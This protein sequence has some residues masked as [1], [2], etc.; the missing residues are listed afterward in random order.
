MS[1]LGSFCCNICG[2]ADFKSER[3]L[4]MH[5][6]NS[7]KCKQDA[8][9]FPWKNAPARHG[10]LPNS[11]GA[12]PP[13][14][15]TRL[16]VQNAKV[17]NPEPREQAKHEIP[18][19]M[20]AGGS[21]DDDPQPPFPLLF[22]NEYCGPCEENVAIAEDE[23]LKQFREYCA[24]QRENTMPFQKKMRDAILL[25]ELLREKGATLDTYEAVMLWH[26][27]VTGELKPNEGLA[28]ASQ[29]V[30]RNKIMQYLAKRYN[31]NPNYYDVAHI[32]L[33]YSRADINKITHS[34]KS[35]VVEL[36]TDP[37]FQD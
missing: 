11:D 17:P 13:A 1:N 16:H 29:F 24:F 3:G 34:A 6:L 32:K 28:Q 26:F 14:K 12:Q 15:R 36:L 10:R 9:D 23:T 2:R 18:I 21:D 25:M 35:L 31:R 30:S 8:Q 20:V 19:E 5:H 37:R 7:W 33:P 22:G 27:R 4:K